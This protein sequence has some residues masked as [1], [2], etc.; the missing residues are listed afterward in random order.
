MPPITKPLGEAGYSIPHIEFTNDDPKGADS[1]FLRLVQ[2]PESLVAELSLR[3]LTVLYPQDNTSVTNEGDESVGPPGPRVVKLKLIVRH[4]EGIAETEGD[5]DERRIHLS[6]GYMESLVA[7]GSDGSDALALREIQGVILHELVHVYQHDGKHGGESG[8]AAPH[9]W[10]EG[11]ADWIRLQCGLYPPHWGWRNQTVVAAPPE[12]W[13]AGY[14]ETAKFLDFVE[15]SADP[16]LAGFVAEMNRRLRTASWSDD[17]VKEVTGGRGM[18]SLWEEFVVSVERKRSS[19]PLADIVF[20]N[21]DPA[22][23]ESKFLTIIP[24]PR[25]HMA[26]I[27]L[28]LLKELYQDCPEA[29]PHISK[30]TLVIRPFDGVAHTTGSLKEREIHVSTTYIDAQSESDRFLHEVDGLLW[31]EGLHVFHHDGRGPNNKP[32]TVPKGFVEGLA[33]LIR[34]RQCLDPPSWR[35]RWEAPGEDDRWDRGYEHTAYFL[36]FIEEQATPPTPGFSNAVNR[37]LKNEE[38]TDSIFEQLTGR[39]VNTLWEDYVN[40][41]KLAP[42][43]QWPSPPVFVISQ[44]LS[45]KGVILFRKLFS[46]PDA[47]VLIRSIILNVL[48]TLYDRISDAPRE[49]TAINIFVRDFPGV[50]YATG[51]GT[52]KEIHL[53]AQHIANCSGNGDEESLKKLEHEIRGVLCHEMVHCWQYNASDTANGGLIEG[54]ADFVRLKNSLAPP[55][56]SPGAKGRK[57][58]SGYEATAYFLE[59]IEEKMEPPLPGFVRI[60]NSI[61]GDRDWR[62]DDGIFETLTGRSLQQLWGAYKKSFIDVGGKRDDQGWPIPEY[63]VE[64]RVEDGGVFNVAVPPSQAVA[65]FRDLSM[66]ALKLL[67]EDPMKS[68]G[69]VI[70]VTLIVREMDGVAHC[71]GSDQEKEIHLSS[72][73]LAGQSSSR[74]RQEIEGVLVHELVHVWQLTSSNMSGGLVEGIADW[75]RLRADKAPPHWKRSFD[76]TWDGGYDKTAYFLDWLETGI[77]GSGFVSKLNEE[78]GEVDEWDEGVIKKLCADLEVGELWQMYRESFD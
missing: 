70:T 47:H 43:N 16:P 22:G 45:A 26:A 62:W 69:S 1:T 6:V 5:L 8:Q 44:D 48:K 52:G 61:M 67:Y 40:Y 36:M 12:S 68:P 7:D 29:A 10:I 53:S 31:H 23:D 39:T 55:H 21:E 28:G 46:A 19:W 50:A 54:I 34:M 33:D 15:T 66:K 75:V 2:D 3:V 9:G 35:K 14:H 18:A 51:N 72:Q 4:K 56:W 24:T 32:P 78:M 59:F 76:G 38:W 27:S 71:T 41:F 65:L 42:T 20:R 37:L 30:L 64:N 73:Y 77:G 57:W 74:L 13:D 11:V 17:L 60:L 49:A 58:D 25:A 63:K